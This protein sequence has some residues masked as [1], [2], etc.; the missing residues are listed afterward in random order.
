MVGAPTAVTCLAWVQNILDLASVSNDWTEAID[1]A[2]ILF[3]LILAGLVAQ[4][5]VA[6]S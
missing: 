1:G 3:A 4:E 6:S 5:A 2:V